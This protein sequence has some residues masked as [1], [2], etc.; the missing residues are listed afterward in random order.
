MKKR[1]RDDTRL[2]RDDEM[3]RGGRFSESQDGVAV[4]ISR[5]VGQGRRKTEVQRRKR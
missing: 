4:M 5:E 2:E 1:K 3:L